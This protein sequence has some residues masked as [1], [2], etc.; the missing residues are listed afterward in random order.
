MQNTRQ[1]W[2]SVPLIELPDGLGY[3]F[4]SSF[5]AM[6]QRQFGVTPGEYAKSVQNDAASIKRCR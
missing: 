3:D 6:F 4:P 1:D 2:D 5:I